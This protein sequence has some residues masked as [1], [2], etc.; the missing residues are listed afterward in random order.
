M[1]VSED[2]DALRAARTMLCKH[3]LDIS[4]TDVHVSHGICYIR[5][6]V[7]AEAGSPIE[8]VSSEVKRVALLIRQKPGIR[9]V[10]LELDAA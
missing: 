3:G 10:I 5:G 7:R 2:R 9:N 1:I 4:R 6:Q 8:D